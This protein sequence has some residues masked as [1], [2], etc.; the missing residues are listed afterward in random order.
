MENATQA[1]T[2]GTQLSYDLAAD[3]RRK[4]KWWG[5]GAP[6]HRY[7]LTHM[8]G[9]LEYLRRRLGIEALR[10]FEPPVIDAVQMPA[11]QASPDLVQKLSAIVGGEHCRTGHRERV[12]HSVGKGYKDLVRL[13]SLRLPLATDAVV[14]PQTAEQ[15]A[16]ILALCR[17]E[18][19]A[20]IPFGGGSCVVSGLDAERGKQHA[21]ISLDLAF[22]NRLLTI[23]ESSLTANFEAG[24][25]GPELEA[26][27]RERGFTL[28]H[29]PQS[30]EYSTLGG[31]IA[32]R[33]S[34]QNS[35]GYGGID[36]LV[37][38]IVAVT[39]IG[40]IRTLS[41]PRRADGPDVNQVLLGSEGT[42]G[43]ITAATVRIRRLPKARDY[44]MFVFKS[45][46]SAIDACRELVQA[47][48]RP[49]L[50]RIS[51]EEETQGTLAMGQ[52]AAS[53]MKQAKRRAAQ[54]LLEQRGFR[55]PALCTVLVG[56]EGVA[57]AIAIERRQIRRH[58]QQR[59]GF[60]L[61]KSPGER[62]LASRFE[63]PYLRD[64]LIYN[65]LLI[66]TLE[67]ATTWSQLP[68]V[69]NAV[70]KALSEAAMAQ[71]YPLMVYCHVS[72]FYPDGASLYFTLLGRQDRVDPIA[73]WLRIKTAANEA[74]R[75]H[76]AA[77]SHHHGVGLDHREHT[78]RGE[79]EQAML[80]QLKRTLDPDD[81]MNPGKL[82]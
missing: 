2:R 34:G 71:G 7:P 64:E 47:G 11:S 82:L 74:I 70:R 5:W 25:F 17:S 22:L 63:L 45:F 15:V 72:H 59:G 52:S 23:D 41:V 31:W 32:M 73:Q 55:P 51:D 54:W 40:E 20:V 28:G 53:G 42:L 10:E 18:R 24:C 67:T 4:M 37:E 35:L 3:E 9:A 69:Y 49:A 57:D 76:G 77:I 43:V 29:F 12:L 78:G 65:D 21:V 8:P 26:A 58:L 6:E 61:G 81:I 33:S 79:V 30:F 60:Y 13:R 1:R 68:L 38:R 66:D 16:N 48:A 62:W 56:L 36:R 39:P 46:T 44:F 27:L 75:R 80:A 14:Y 19:V 50:L